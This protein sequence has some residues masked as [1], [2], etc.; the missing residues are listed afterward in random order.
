MPTFAP[1]RNFV[2]AK[3]KRKMKNNNEKTAAV[4]GLGMMGAT[5]A[6]LLLAAG[7]E[8]TV[9]NRNKDKSLPLAEAGAIVAETPGAAVNAGQVIVMCV[10]DYAAAESILSQ[11]AQSGW[12]GKVLVQLTSG[13]PAEAERME[14]WTESLGARYLDGAIQA[15]PQQMGREDTPLF[16]SGNAAA[17]NQALPVLKVF[18][19]SPEWL[20]IPA[21]LASSVDLAT[22]SGI[23]GTMMGF[24][25]GARIMEHA[26]F[27][28][29]KYAALL[30]GI[31][32]TFGDFIQ[33]EG[34][35]VHQNRFEKSE[36]PMSISVDATARIL[37]QAQESGIHDKFPLYAAGMFR[38]AA[39]KGLANEELA[40]M[41]KVLRG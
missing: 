25:H 16:I 12:K 20:G 22:L 23:Y 30:S 39:E 24:F 3:N 18:A 7:Y 21:G 1:A 41:I 36:S 38:E 28:V 9:W 10:H 6:K 29:D 11:T 34:Q 32:S 15:A 27:P 40:A 26:G 17:W 35:L 37:R 31:L 5:L 33:L 14:Q 19:G 13:S 8:V 2:P 4:L